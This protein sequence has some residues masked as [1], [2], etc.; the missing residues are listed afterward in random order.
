MVVPPVLAWISQVQK[1]L[2][3]WINHPLFSKDLVT[4]NEYHHLYSLYAVEYLFHN[5]NWEKLDL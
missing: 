5:Q 1:I 3:Q 4:L 2:H